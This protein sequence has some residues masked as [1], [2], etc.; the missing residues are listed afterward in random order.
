MSTEKSTYCTGAEP[1]RRDLFLNHERAR[2]LTNKNYSHPLM[3]I[4]G[5]RSLMMSINF[6]L[7]VYERE[8]LAGVYGG[9]RDEALDKLGME[10]GHCASCKK[11]NC[12]DE[13]R[14]RHC[15][16]RSIIADT[17]TDNNRM[18][19][20]PAVGNLCSPPAGPTT[21]PSYRAPTA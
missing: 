6:I 12:S 20:K 5:A 7:M 9:F 11:E 1:A 8:K 3:L 17:G 4:R 21:S 10:I 14:L 16:I 19:G 18:A 13:A 2:I 15:T